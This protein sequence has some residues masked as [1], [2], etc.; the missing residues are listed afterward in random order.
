MSKIET[1]RS[2]VIL[3]LFL[4][5]FFGGGLLATAGS[6][7]LYLNWENHF[8][9]MAELQDQVRAAKEHSKADEQAEKDFER[10]G[11]NEWVDE[12][13]DQYTN[14]AEEATGHLEDDLA[15]S[16]TAYSPEPVIPA[17][18]DEENASIIELRKEL[19]E[20]QTPSDLITP[21]P[22]TDTT[23]VPN[24]PNTSP[25]KNGGSIEKMEDDWLPPGVTRSK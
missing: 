4:L 7:Y 23:A 2:T 11:V 12:L 1:P 9:P 15:N 14:R 19:A 13:G 16:Q 20:F 21:V 18:T 6:I 24:N 22:E 3:P 17:P 8:P 10:T 5:L 25:L